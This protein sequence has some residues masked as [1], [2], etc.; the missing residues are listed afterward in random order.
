M[1]H[2]G[3][4]KDVAGHYICTAPINKEKLSNMKKLKYVKAKFLFTNG[5]LDE[6][7]EKIVNCPH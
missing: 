4:L 7:I 1:L 5:T 2:H 6:G 3:L